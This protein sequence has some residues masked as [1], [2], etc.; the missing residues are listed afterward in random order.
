MIGLRKQCRQLVVSAALALLTGS[1]RL[2]AGDKSVT[3]KPEESSQDSDQLDRDRAQEAERVQAASSKTVRRFHEVLDELLAEFGYDVKMGQIQALK[4]VAL[5]KVD[6]SDALP[7][8]YRKYTEVL[9][10]E[11]IRENST[12]RIINCTPCSTKTSKLVEGK[13]LITSP[14]TNAAMLKTVADQLGIENFMDVVL[15]YHTTHMV[16]A[17]EVFNVATNEMVWARTYN[18]ET[19]KS[20]YQ[21]LAID[22]R[23]VEKSRPGEDY[24]PEYRILS[25]LGGASIPNVGGD[26]SDKTMLNLQVRATE[27]FD[28]RR[29]EFGL[30]LSVFKSLNSVLKKY[31]TTGTDTT[32][33]TG[34]TEATGALKPKPFGTGVILAGIYSHNFLGAVESYNEVRQGLHVGLGFFAAAGYLAPSFDVGWDIYFG[35]RFSTGF[36]AL[37][38]GESQIL[39]G[40]EIVKTP[41]GGGGSIVLS[42]NY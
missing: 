29:S 2:Y 9:V 3:Q 19:I 31:P 6:V 39:V 11:R 5:R 38:F 24:S 16:L 41:G 37:Y 8:T 17:F 35:R 40:N 18:S 21:K 25:G 4:N 23:Q 1:A 15:V 10:A 28:N 12:V 33:A 36:S 20:R 27:K 34:E 13:L 42:V 32:A 26:S 14:A 22:Y 7:D 30:L